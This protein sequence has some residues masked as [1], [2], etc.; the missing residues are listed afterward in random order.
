MLGID[1]FSGRAAAAGVVV[2]VVIFGAPPTA[3]GILAESF[4][5]VPFPPIRCPGRRFGV[6]LKIWVSLPKWPSKEK[7]PQHKD[8]IPNYFFGGNFAAPGADFR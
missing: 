5:G 8:K 4:P 1:R 3:G 6:V 2:I 7:F